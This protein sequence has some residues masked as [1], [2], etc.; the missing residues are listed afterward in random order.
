MCALLPQ[1]RGT[2]RYGISCLILECSHCLNS[3]LGVWCR[4]VYASFDNFV[5][6]VL[7]MCFAE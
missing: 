1:K 3:L 2:W 5:N 6:F 7:C 4:G